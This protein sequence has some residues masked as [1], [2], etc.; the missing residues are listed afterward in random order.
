MGAYK[1]KGC[2]KIEVPRAYVGS[3][4]CNLEGLSAGIIPDGGMRKRYLV[5]CELRRD[6][7]SN[8]S[9]RLR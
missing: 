2:V 9:G 4:A 8:V 3:E 7:V 5:G 6:E 1:M